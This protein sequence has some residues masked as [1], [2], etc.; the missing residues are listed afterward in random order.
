[1]MFYFILTS[2]LKLFWATNHHP[3]QKIAFT[4]NFFVS[5]VQQFFGFIS[6]GLFYGSFSA[7]VRY[8]IK[9]DGLE[10]FNDKLKKFL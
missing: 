10:L 3:L 8:F 5:V 7:F 9:E 6:S 1:M 2:G 4:I